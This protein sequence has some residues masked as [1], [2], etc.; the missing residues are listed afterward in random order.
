MQQTPPGWALTQVQ[1]WVLSLTNLQ[2]PTFGLYVEGYETHEKA[3]SKEKLMIR[4]VRLKID[5]ERENG[6]E[7]RARR[8]RLVVEYLL[9]QVVFS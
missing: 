3:R 1:V 8:D 6:G 2:N 9:L 4:Y 7:K 5:G